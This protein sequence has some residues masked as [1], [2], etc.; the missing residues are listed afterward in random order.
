VSGVA[1]GGIF[2]FGFGAERF[3]SGIRTM[4]TVQTCRVQ[5]LILGTLV[6][7]GDRLFP[8]LGLKPRC[9]LAAEAAFA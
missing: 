5:T 6:P 9:A 3:F 4:V 2:D 1:E 8:G 7:P